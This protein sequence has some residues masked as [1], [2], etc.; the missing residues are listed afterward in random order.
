MA[1]GVERARGGIRG[2]G[3]AAMSDA[4]IAAMHEKR[5]AILREISLVKHGI[6]T[7][8][9]DGAIEPDDSYKISSTT[10]SN[11]III[12]NSI[13]ATFSVHD[14]EGDGGVSV[15]MGL[16][17]HYAAGNNNFSSSPSES[18]FSKRPDPLKEWHIHDPKM[19][20]SIVDIL[21]R[22]KIETANG[23]LFAK[24]GIEDTLY[25]DAAESS[26]LLY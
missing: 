1:N 11:I 18:E 22:A 14:R 26:G 10:R 13:A 19:Y 9:I 4:D 24:L 3:E 21:K 8:L 25:E 12:L 6:L 15:T 17:F 5:K 7:K 20:D 23:L 2:Y 16:Q